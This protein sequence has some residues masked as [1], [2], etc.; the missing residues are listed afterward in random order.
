MHELTG[1]RNPDRPDPVRW[2]GLW[3][4]TDEKVGAEAT[5]AVICGTE[6][7]IQ[8]G[9]LAAL[10]NVASLL[11][12]DDTV[13]GLYVGCSSDWSRVV[14]VILLKN[15]DSYAA[16][17]HAIYHFK[18]GRC[19]C[20][21]GYGTLAV[22]DRKAHWSWPS[23]IV[24]AD[25]CGMERT[26]WRFQQDCRPRRWSISHTL[27]VYPC[28][29]IGCYLNVNAAFHQGYVKLQADLSN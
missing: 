28:N 2:R 1:N 15:A 5:T 7:D 19:T 26:Y 14:M 23:E 11:C 12:T 20:V 3:L 24:C 10:K 16:T 13:E 8:R 4:K 6:R 29:T 18:V 25:E 9:V 17:K 27:Y 21:E 22:L